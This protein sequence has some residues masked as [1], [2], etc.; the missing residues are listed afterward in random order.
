MSGLCAWFGPEL[1]PA[2]RAERVKAGAAALR[3]PLRRNVETRFG[4]DALDGVA[5]PGPVAFS[6][7]ESPAWAVGLYGRPTHPCGNGRPFHAAEA[8]DLLE[9]AGPA[10]LDGVD[11]AFLAVALDRIHRRILLHTDRIGSIPV[12]W[13]RDGHALGI[14]T[15]ARALFDA[16]HP[17]RVDDDA[18]LLSLIFGRVKL[19]RDPLFKNCR[20]A[21]PGSR[22]ILG[23]DGDG[24][25]ETWFRGLPDESAATADPRVQIEEAA[26]TLDRT[27]NGLIESAGGTVAMGLSGGLDA[28][29]LAASIRPENRSRVVAVS[30]G[31][32][33]NNETHISRQIARRLGLRHVAMDLTPEHFILC[34]ETA[35]EISE[36]R[37]LYAQGYLLDVLRQAAYAQG[38]A[39]FLDGME[40]GVS[41]GGDYL[42]DG[43]DELTVPELPRWLFNKFIICREPPEQWLARVPAWM[44][45]LDPIR[46]ALE[47]SAHFPAPYDRLDRFYLENYTREVMRLRHRLTRKVV[48]PLSIVPTRAY[49]TLCA[50]VPNRRRQGRR[51]QLALLRHLDPGLLDIPYHGHLM[52]LSAPPEAIRA[53][54]ARLQAEESFAQKVWCDHRVLVPFNHYFTNFAQWYRACPNTVVFI[55]ELLGTPDC[56]IA[57]RLFRPEWIRTVLQEHGDGT[58]DHRTVISYLAGAELFLRR[59]EA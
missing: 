56:R 48:A 27:V 24:A 15:E 35:I 52:P 44:D 51:F 58:R 17:P 38:A 9:A 36:G 41:L 37:D 3:A 53:A 28:R 57:G 14:A 45:T 16:A 4:A 30:F 21:A 32:E 43:F 2:V 25:V 42:S 7:A 1:D 39:A 6:W 26:A 46:R 29:T 31:M 49:Q 34:A 22:V 59:F 20:A 8:A 33:G 23:A 47:E 19:S 11:G 18:L 40:V 5:L 55:H 10:A 50:R 13:R 54:R 12:Y